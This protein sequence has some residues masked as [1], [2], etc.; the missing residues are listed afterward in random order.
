[1]KYPSARYL[2][3]PWVF[4]GIK[5]RDKEPLMPKRHSSSQMRNLVKTK[6]ALKGKSSLILGQKGPITS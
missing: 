2:V 6:M 4:L 1:M 3:C 5:R